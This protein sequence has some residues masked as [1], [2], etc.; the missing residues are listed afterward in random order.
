MCSVLVCSYEYLRGLT[1]SY[2]SICNLEIGLLL[3][4]EGHRLKNTDSKTW[5]ALST[6]KAKRR[7]ILT[8]TPIQVCLLLV[9][10]KVD[11][12]EINGFRTILQ[13]TSPFSVSHFPP[14]S[15]HE[16]TSA[17][18]SKTQSFEGAMLTRPT[19]LRPRVRKDS[20]SSPRSY[21]N[22]S[23]AARTTCFPNTVGTSNVDIT[24]MTL[25]NYRS[26]RQIRTRRLLSYVRHPARHVLLLRR[27]PEDEG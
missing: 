19:L 7:V 24:S 18:T 14:T 20:K 2:P 26:T 12:I 6:L 16:T 8:G 17:R 13:S 15:E 27:P 5:T 10:F 3:C 22:S 25:M 11:L 1:I 4:D 21:R 23:F 9:H